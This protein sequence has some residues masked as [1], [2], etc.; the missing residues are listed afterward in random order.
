MTVQMAVDDS[1]NNNNNNN[2][3]NKEAALAV[4]VD[5]TTGRVHL[6]RTDGWIGSFDAG[7]LASSPRIS[8]DLE[9]G[10]AHKSHDEAVYRPFIMPAQFADPCCG[11]FRIGHAENTPIGKP[12]SNKCMQP[13]LKSAT[14]KTMYSKPN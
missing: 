4:R 9:S 11:G 6:L 13:A 1:P 3:N 7:R 2:N 14:A 10:T 12:R 8:T 5:D